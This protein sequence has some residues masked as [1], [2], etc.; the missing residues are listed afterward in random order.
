LLENLLEWT[1]SQQGKLTSNPKL[2]EVR[3]HVEKT[4]DLLKTRADKKGVELRIDIAA[5]LATYADPMLFDNTM[6]NITNNAI[7]FTPGGGTIIISSVRKAKHILVCCTDNGIGI[8]ANYLNDL[9]R[10]DGK[11]K[12]RGTDQEPGTGL[13]LILCKEYVGLMNGKITVVSNEKDGTK[14]CIELPATP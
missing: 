6:L 1:N 9:F 7:K 10:L 8:P 11:V 5:Y 2:I 13:G 3:Q 4:V 12:R 14:V